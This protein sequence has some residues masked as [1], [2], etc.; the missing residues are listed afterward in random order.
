MLDRV[1]QPAESGHAGYGCRVMEFNM[2]GSDDT[3]E[4]QHTQCS[5]LLFLVCAAQ[6][7]AFD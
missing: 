4:C 6:L 2:A 1:R 3:A 7:Y 5:S